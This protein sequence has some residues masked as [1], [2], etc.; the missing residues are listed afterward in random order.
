MNITK[1]LD[2]RLVSA[3]RARRGGALIVAAALAGATLLSACGSSSS[4]NSTPAGSTPT[5]TAILNTNHVALAIKQSILSERHIHAKVTCPKVVPQQK[6]RNFACLAS[7]GKTK[8]PVAVTQQ[9]DK[10]YVTY[11]VE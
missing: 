2:S 3:V 9:N 11:H 6:G 7:T 8:E 5:P 1:A 10:G 4:S